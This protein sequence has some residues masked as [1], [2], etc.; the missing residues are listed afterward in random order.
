MII[1]IIKSNQRAERWILWGISWSAMS[2]VSRWASGELIPQEMR[3]TT[4]KW[5][6]VGYLGE[7]DS[8]I[9]HLDNQIIPHHQDACRIDT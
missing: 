8:N 1:R 5:G 2:R 9:D 4:N 3:K 7:G 6:K